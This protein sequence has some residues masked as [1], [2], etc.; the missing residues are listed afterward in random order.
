MRLIIA[1]IDMVDEFSNYNCA[2]SI[3]KAQPLNKKHPAWMQLNKPNPEF[4]ELV[5][6]KEILFFFLSLSKATQSYVMPHLPRHLCSRGMALEVG[7]RLQGSWALPFPRLDPW[8][9]VPI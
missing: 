3:L 1:A 7:A 4:K 2:V 5:G 8:G 6:L 9:P